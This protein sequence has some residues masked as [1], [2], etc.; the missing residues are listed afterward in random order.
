[1]AK[2][3]KKEKKDKKEK[4]KSNFFKELKA[5]MKKV[6]WPTLKKLVNNTSA[7]ISIV[8]IMAIIVFVLDVCFENLN[9]FGVGKLKEL[10]SS[11]TAETEEIT[12]GDDAEEI[13]EEEID[14]EGD[15]SEKEN[16]ETNPETEQPVEETDI[17]SE[18]E[19]NSEEVVQE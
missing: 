3:E 19:N 7:V 12:E 5:E 2:K 11:D 8:L 13:S 4:K 16:L 1:M 18:T 10:V 6:T 14:L 9:K 15:V 17:N